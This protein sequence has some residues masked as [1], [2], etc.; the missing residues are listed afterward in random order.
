MSTPVE[1]FAELYG[2][3]DPYGYRDRW[4]EERKRQLLLA[5]L[6]QRRFVSAWELG[7]SNGELTAALASRCDALLATDQSE[8]AVALAKARTAGA[9]FGHVVVRQAK[10]PEQWPSENFDLIVFSEVGYFMDAAALERT[11]EGLLDAVNPDGT[12]IACHWLTRFAAAAQTGRE[13]HA[14][15]ARAIHLPELFRY[16]D[17]DFLLE[18]WSAAPESIAQ[19]EGLR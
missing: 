1:Y 12:V 4:Y 10:H 6:P 13:V 5:S 8:R 14:A 16:E 15:I 2:S 9:E 3:D 11:V 7:C 18:G 19:R 17:N